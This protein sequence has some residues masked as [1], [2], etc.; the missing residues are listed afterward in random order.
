MPSSERL[1]S[2]KLAYGSPG[3]SFGKKSTANLWLFRSK[4]CRPCTL[5]TIGLINVVNLVLFCIFQ[6]AIFFCQYRFYIYLGLCF[7]VFLAC[8]SRTFI[9]MENRDLQGSWGGATV[10]QDYAMMMM[11]INET[12]NCKLYFQSNLQTNIACDVKPQQ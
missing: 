2:S 5:Q 8:V 7:L 6:F 9:S 12:E 3:V 11:M 4:F 1:S 10:R